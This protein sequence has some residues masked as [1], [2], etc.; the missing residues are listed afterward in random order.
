M[1]ILPEMKA[2]SSFKKVK[3]TRVAV[4]ESL[5]TFAE[6]SEGKTTLVDIC[7]RIPFHGQTLDFVAA[8]W[9]DGL[10]KPFSKV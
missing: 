10:N 2:E 5:K 4:N 8:H 6:A 3:P 1:R 9:D 7:A